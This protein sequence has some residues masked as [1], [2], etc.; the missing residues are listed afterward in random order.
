MFDRILNHKKG[1]QPFCDLNCCIFRNILHNIPLYK[2]RVFSLIVLF[3]SHAI[4]ERFTNESNLKYTDR[5]QEQNHVTFAGTI[6]R[7]EISPVQGTGDVTVALNR[8]TISVKVI[9]IN[10]KDPSL[11][12]EKEFSSYDDFESSEDFASVEDDLMKI[13]SEKLVALVYN[14][15]IVDW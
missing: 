13:I 5:E 8:L 11:D 14:E 4:H 10:T 7:Y 6:N 1:T 15:T 12:F 3:A 2:E 9:Y